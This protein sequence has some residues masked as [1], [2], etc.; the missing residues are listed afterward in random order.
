MAKYALEHGVAAALC[1]Y[2]KKFPELKENTVRT[3]QNGYIAELQ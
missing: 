1:H 2:I 3:W